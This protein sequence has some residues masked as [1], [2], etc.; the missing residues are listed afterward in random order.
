MAVA[1]DEVDVSS[2]R[3]L[4][5]DDGAVP[6]P[7][8]FVEDVEVVPVEMHRV[9]SVLLVH[10]VRKRAREQTNRKNSRNRALVVDN[11]AN[12]AVVVVVD[13]VPVRVKRKVAVIS[14]Q[15]HWVVVVC[16]HG[17]AVELP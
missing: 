15:Q 2:V 7:D 9:A 5:A 1:A 17:H 4:R 8:A 12:R 13:D 10:V 6:C 11:D 14:V 16:P 3:I